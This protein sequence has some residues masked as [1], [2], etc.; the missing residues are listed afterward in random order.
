MNVS[1]A[2][3]G[4]ERMVFGVPQTVMINNLLCPRKSRTS[5]VGAFQSQSNQP[6]SSLGFYTL[7]KNMEEV[8]RHAETMTSIWLEQEKAIMTDLKHRAAES[9]IWE[10]LNMAHE[11]FV[12]LTDTAENVKLLSDIQSKAKDAK[13]LIQLAETETLNSWFLDEA[14]NIVGD[15]NM[16]LVRYELS[17]HLSGPYDKEGACLTITAGDA[18]ND[19]QEWV[20]ILL[21][22][23]LQWAKKQGYKTRVVEK[24]SGA[25]VGIKSTIEFEWRFAYGLLSGEKGTHQIVRKSSSNEEILEQTCIAGVDVVPLFIE[26]FVYFKLPDEDLEIH[27]TSLSG[28]SSRSLNKA[29][30]AVHIIHIPTGT[31]VYCTGERSPIANKI[32]AIYRLKAKLL[33]VAMEQ[34]TSEIKQIRHENMKANLGQPIRKYVFYPK[35]FVQDLRTGTKMQDIKSIL[36]GKIEPLIKDYLIFKNMQNITS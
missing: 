32:K 20:D 35:T 27:Y 33:A 17:K 3:T 34:Q 25:E 10:D 11:T 18:G 22:M 19:A 9:N 1:R 12:A 31:S 4:I 28:S 30:M 36:N 6:L 8:G 2:M 15:L 29:E 14:F 5:V 26:N 24:Y 13:L 23:Y 7:K 21:R 16:S